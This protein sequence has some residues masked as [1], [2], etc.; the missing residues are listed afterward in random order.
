MTNTFG[1]AALLE[2]Y[3]LGIFPMSDSREDKE[4]FLMDPEV[5]GIIPLDGLHISRSLKKFIRQSN[6]ILRYNQSFPAVIQACAQ[7]DA[8]RENTWI[9]KALESLYINLHENGFA[10]SVEIYEDEVLIGGLYGVVQGSAFFGES[11]FSIKKNAS[12]IALVGLVEALNKN[13]F[14]LLD[15]Q[16]STAHLASL[17]CIEIERE[18][19]Q[20]L[21][22]NALKQEAVFP[23][24]SIAV[25]DLIQSK[26]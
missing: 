9:S 2:C 14:K 5:R 25:A 22:Q 18:R 17:G 6:W 21:L 23:M 20:T 10:Y 1:P 3:R 26:A 12:K 16:F 4:V 13:G 11:M 15:T 24:G 7:P 8:G 19:Y